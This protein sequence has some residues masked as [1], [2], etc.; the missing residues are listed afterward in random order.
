M[1]RVDTEFQF[2]DFSWLI[3]ED[4]VCLL[5]VTPKLLQIAVKFIGDIFCSEWAV[6]FSFSIIKADT[7][8]S[9]LCNQCVF[10]YGISLKLQL[11]VQVILQSGESLSA[12]IS[13]SSI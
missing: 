8:S 9:Y 11:L 3:G 12:T 2:R 6:H 13:F 4:S 5:V 10:S 1:Q 7:Q